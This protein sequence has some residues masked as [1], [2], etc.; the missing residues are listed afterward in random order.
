[1]PLAPG[2]VQKNLVT[3]VAVELAVASLALGL[4]DVLLHV[5]LLPE[6]HAPRRRTLHT[7]RMPCYLER[8]LLGI[9]LGVDE[10]GLRGRCCCG[11][12]GNHLLWRFRG[13]GC[14]YYLDLFGRSRVVH[15]LGRG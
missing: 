6:D 1:M 13:L 12:T 15:L 8:G 7:G 11:N 4:A 5:T 10:Q 14:C 3:F 9:L 2:G